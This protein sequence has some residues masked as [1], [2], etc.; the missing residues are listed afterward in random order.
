MIVDDGLVTAI[1]IA[2]SGA[3][4]SAIIAL[5]VLREQ[6]KAQKENVDVVR[7]LV[8]ELQTSVNKLN[9][10]VVLLTELM[11]VR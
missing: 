9:V 11:K 4:I 3:F 7:L 1:V 2:S 6:V 5:A 8:S 10:E